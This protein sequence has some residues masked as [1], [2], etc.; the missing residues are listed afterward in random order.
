MSGRSSRTGR[1]GR[2]REP[3]VEPDRLRPPVERPPDR[4]QGTSI[5]RASWIGTVVF[6]LVSIP[7]SVAPDTFAPVL[8][9]VS[10][11]LFV[12]GLVVFVAAFLIAVGRSR[13]VLIGMGGLFFLAGGT[14]PLRV[15]RHLVG[16]FAVECVL[17]VATTV[18]G[19]FT[20]PADVTNPVAFGVLVPIYGLALAGL[21]A[22]RYG[23]FD[24]RP[25]EPA[26]RGRRTTS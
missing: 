1:D 14:A 12:A 19:L 11:A 7:A 3:P 23:R 15:A 20:V 10:L 6:A 8:I 2:H 26:A 22:A 9:M 13:E 4:R 17:A 5:I 25:P 18:V 21:W 24:D 16:S